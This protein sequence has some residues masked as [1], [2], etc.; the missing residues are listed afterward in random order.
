MSAT[1]ARDSVLNAV[2]GACTT[3]GGFLSSI[4]VARLL[5]VEGTGVFAFSVWLVTMAVMLSD[6]GV[7]GSLARYLPELHARRED[8]AAKGLTGFLLRRF[9]IALFF[10]FLGFFGYAAWLYVAGNWHGFDIT[11]ASY[12][13]DPFFW[14][15]V[16]VAFLAQAL[17]GCLNGYFKGM[18]DFRTMAR[19][20]M[21]SA[22]LQLS[23]TFI[24]AVMLGIAGA[25]IGA[26]AGSL[27]PAALIG[28][29]IVGG[30]AIS[31]ELQRRAT[32]FAWESWGG[33]L[34]TAFAWSRMEIF[35]LERSWGSHAVGLF[36]VSLTM[37]N[38]ATQGPLLLTGALLPY[39]S[40]QHG[41]G[42]TEKARETYAASM[43]IMASLIFP[44]CLGVAAIAPVLLPAL[45]G[46]AFSAAVLPAII[47]VSAAALSATASVAF[48][49]LLAMERTRFVFVSGSI[50]AALCILAGITVIPAFGAIAAA[51]ARA[52]IQTAI[53]GA[54]VWYVG[55]RLACPPPI[56]SLMRILAAALLC[57]FT[58]RIC[59]DLIGGVMS[60][61]IAIPL[62][63]LV[64]AISIRMLNAL[65]AGD[66]DRLVRAVTI[67]PKPMPRIMGALLQLLAPSRVRD[68][69]ES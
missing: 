39:L 4:M 47:L 27:V 38:L 33:Y 57:A 44:A 69:G 58:A 55:R 45:Y 3:L 66:L 20:A 63:A 15:L 10:V 43:R 46:R 29:V 13:H 40:H 49:Y 65:P 31:G 51:I 2:A 8:E 67:L 17:A 48:T 7:P 60:L 59:V 5:G 25:L 21:L 62:G 9:L 24:G 6:V 11:A 61:C 64:Y 36:S 18:R 53:A 37:A 14:S 35:F 41:A 16:G 30:E 52:V 28:R 68:V 12:R 1:F 56:A 32:R 26:I 54:T 22:A 34:V 23:A 19:L 50:G 42:A